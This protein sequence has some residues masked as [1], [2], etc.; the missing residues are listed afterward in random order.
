MSNK[1]INN[2][3]HHN[4]N[5]YL[6]TTY[7]FAKV[8]RLSS[9]FSGQAFVYKYRRYYYIF[10][11]K[12]IEVLYLKIEFLKIYILH[13]SEFVFEGMFEGIICLKLTGYLSIEFLFTVY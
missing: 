9:D 12:N 7:N 1:N 4:Q 10:C 5:K 2:Y 3:S 13:C 6:R 8:S 11:G